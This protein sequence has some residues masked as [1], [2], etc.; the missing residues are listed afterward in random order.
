MAEGQG[1]RGAPYGSA[2]ATKKHRLLSDQLKRELTQHPEKVVEIVTRLIDDA[3]NGDQAARMLI[4]ERVDGK[5]PQ[6][7]VGDDDEPA[8]TIRGL[9]DL[10]RPAA[11]S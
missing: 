9:I 10:V 3:V 1:R 4:F 11:G 2:N 7:L 5:V 6:P 8:I